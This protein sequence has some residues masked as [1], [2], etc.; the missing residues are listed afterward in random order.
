MERRGSLEEE[1]EEGRKKTKAR[2]GE[3]EKHEHRA[4]LNRATCKAC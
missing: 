2:E 3:T 4:L 1:E